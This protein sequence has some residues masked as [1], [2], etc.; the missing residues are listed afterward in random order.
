MRDRGAG[1]DLETVPEDRHGVRESIIGR[2]R[3]H[4]GSATITSTPGVGTE[5]ALVL[6]ENR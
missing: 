5:V 1:F 4:G 3:R 2:M 6:E